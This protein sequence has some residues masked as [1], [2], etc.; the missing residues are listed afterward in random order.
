MEASKTRDLPAYF[1]KAIF[2]LVVFD[3]AMIVEHLPGNGNGYLFRYY[4]GM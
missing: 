2:D 4:P 1:E 3:S